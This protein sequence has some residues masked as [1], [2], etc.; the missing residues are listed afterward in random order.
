MRCVTSMLSRTYSDKNKLSFPSREA[1]GDS[2]SKAV[3]ERGAASPLSLLPPDS[4]AGI[5]RRRRRRSRLLAVKREWVMREGVGERIFTT[6]PL[7]LMNL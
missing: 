5:C 3:D 4:Q 2:T 1:A 7:N 6:T